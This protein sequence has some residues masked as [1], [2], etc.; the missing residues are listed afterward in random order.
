MGDVARTVLIVEDDDDIRDVVSHI[1]ER[2]GYQVLQA[3][4]GREALDQLQPHAHELCLV[5]LDLMMPVMSGAEFLRAVSKVRFVVPPIVVLSAIADRER[6][7]G[8]AAYVRKPSSEAELL[9]IV[10]AY[11]DDARP[12]PS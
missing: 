1:I 8:A 2:A 10:R 11:C 4:N 6:P 3:R 9:R 7:P 5:L 12:P